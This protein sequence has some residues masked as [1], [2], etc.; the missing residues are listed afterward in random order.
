MVRL[1]ILKIILGILFSIFTLTITAYAAEV[2]LAWDA[3][4]ES[5]L[6]GSKIYYGIQSRSNITGAIETWCATN[7]HY[8]GQCEDQCKNYF[9]KICTYNNKFDPAC[10]YQLFEYEKIIDVKNVTMHTIRDLDPGE[11]YYFSATAYDTNH[12][13]SV[14]SI[15]LQHNVSDGVPVE[16][17]YEIKKICPRCHGKGEIE[18]RLVSPPDYADDEEIITCPECDGAKFVDFGT[19]D[20]SDIDDKLNDISEKIDDIFERLLEKKLNNQT[21]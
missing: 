12:H 10:N 18:R 15:E 9:K 3:N 1:K 2:V 8:K 16:A 21:P 5:D 17:P 20:L 14:F 6:A 19:I 7:R 11:T 4:T 13:E